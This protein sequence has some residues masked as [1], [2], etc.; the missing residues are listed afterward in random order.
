M[1]DK[2][3]HGDIVMLVPKKGEHLE[4][5]GLAD[6]YICSLAECVCTSMWFGNL[7]FVSSGKGITLRVHHSDMVLVD[8]PKRKS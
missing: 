3:K 5:P 6:D 7:S 4:T 1:S 8:R 2:F